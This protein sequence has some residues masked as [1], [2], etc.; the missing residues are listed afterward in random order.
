MKTICR[1]WQSFWLFTGN[2]FLLA[3]LTVMTVGLAASAAEV[4]PQKPNVLFIVIDDLRP[5]LGCYGK[6]YIH[7]PNIDRLAVRGMVFNQAYCQQAVC[8]PSRTSV[9][10]GVRPDTSKVWDLTTSFR[11][12]LPDVVTLGSNSCSTVILCRVSAKFI[13]VV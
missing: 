8:S 4:S 6:D 10:T 11:K 9:L 7:S 12:T 3:A 1:L 5:E 13:T 2:C